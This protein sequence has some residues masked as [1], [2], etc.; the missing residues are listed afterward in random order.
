ML[1]RCLRRHAARAGLNDLDVDSAGTLG[2]HD[3]PASPE[4]VQAVREVGLDLS[5]HRSRGVV[6]EDLIAVDVV[7]AMTRAHLVELASRFPEGTPRRHVIRAFESGP[8]V[9][10]DAP[11]LADPIGKS[12]AF[13]RDQLQT[14]ER[15]AE[16]LV[17]FLKQSR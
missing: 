7:I 3:A 14:I 16:N 13:Y 1:A 11:D 4:A 12:I 2:I 5:D 8:W 6:A 9:E 17:A 10:Q 15:C